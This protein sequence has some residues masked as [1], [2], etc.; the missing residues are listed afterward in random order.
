VGHIKDV[1]GS[2]LGS[3]LLFAVLGE[4]M[5]ILGLP[6]TETGRKRQRSIG[7]AAAHE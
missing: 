2:F 7:L 5:L 4:L 6:I 1:T 3:M